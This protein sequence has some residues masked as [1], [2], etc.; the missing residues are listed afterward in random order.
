MVLQA[1]AVVLPSMEASLAPMASQV[2]EEDPSSEEG[3]RLPLVCLPVQIPW[4]ASSWPRTC[5]E[6]VPSWMVVLDEDL[7][8][9]S[10]PCGVVLHP[11]AASGP[12]QPSKTERD[13]IQA[14][15]LD[16]V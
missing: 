2:L 15:L 5:A 11:T 13:S 9:A 3:A 16:I 4:A 8:D 7:R 1:P 6:V 14:I 12:T 10:Y